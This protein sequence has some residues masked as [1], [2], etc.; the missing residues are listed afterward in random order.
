MLKKLFSIACGAADIAGLE[1]LA[2]CGANEIFCGF[3]DCSVTSSFFRIL[4]RR[5]M[6]VANIATMAQLSAFINKCKQLGLKVHITLNEI[7][8]ASQYEFVKQFLDQIA[9]L[10]FNGLIISDFGLLLY[11]EREYAR[12]FSIHMGTGALSLNAQTVRHY[13]EFGAQRIIFSRKIFTNEIAEIVKKF[14][15]IQTEVFMETGAYCPNFDGLCNMLHNNE[16]CALGRCSSIENSYPIAQKHGIFNCGCKLCAL[17][18]YKRIGITS[19]KIPRRESAPEEAA[20]FVRFVRELEE[21]S[22]EFTKR[23][24]VNFVRRRYKEHY[25]KQCPIQENCYL[26]QEFDYDC[27]H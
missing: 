12:K 14:P 6:R 20:D 11:I 4:N 24:F 27:N 10:P 16:H 19:L 25:H 2:K 23:E 18:D 8:S 1:L 13:I 26:A 21:K 17:W 9:D 5:E 7:Y 3:Q 15:D 22:I